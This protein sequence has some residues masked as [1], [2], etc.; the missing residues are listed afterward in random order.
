MQR[1]RPLRRGCHT[2]HALQQYAPRI[3]S[4]VAVWPAVSNMA[5]AAAVALPLLSSAAVATAGR[6]RDGAQVSASAGTAAFR[7]RGRSRGRRGRHGGHHAATQ[8]CR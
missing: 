7:V 5:I 8:R 3:S 2:L 4:T 6:W 1:R